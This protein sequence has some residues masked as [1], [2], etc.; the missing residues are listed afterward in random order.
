M[1]DVAGYYTGP[2]IPSKANGAPLPKYMVS[3]GGAS[4]LPSEQAR[5]ESSITIRPFS[6]DDDTEQS[7][8]LPFFSP[9]S[10]YHLKFLSLHF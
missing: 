9:A 7:Y 1:S 10:Y 8:I 6:N 4:I 5:F 2:V 3:N